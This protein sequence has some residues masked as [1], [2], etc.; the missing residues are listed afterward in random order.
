MKDYF[1]RVSATYEELRPLFD[2]MENNLIAYEHSENAL[3]IHVHFLIEDLKESTD[4]LKNWIRKVTNRKFKAD[5]WSFKTKYKP[6]KD[7]LAPEIPVSRTCITY[8][9]KG[10]LEPVYNR[11]FKEEDILDLKLKW[12]DYKRSAKQQ[13][14]TSYLVRESVA[15]SKLRQDQMMQEIIKRLETLEIDDWQ[16]T[17][18]IV[19]SMIRQV[20][21]V[22]NKTIIGRYKVRDYYDTVLAHKHPQGWAAKMSTF[23]RFMQ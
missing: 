9:A 18:D 4:T 17:P 12:I 1:C 11:G 22:E 3:N 8:M 21:I 5:E 14:L 2:R 16:Y 23:V 20:V 10:K 6:S 19:L 13:A 15:Q 7:K